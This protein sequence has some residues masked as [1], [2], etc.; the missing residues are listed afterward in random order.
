[1]K[2]C[3]RCKITS[4]TE[5]QRKYCS[6]CGYEKW[7]ASMRFKR[8]ITEGSFVRKQITPLTDD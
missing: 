2:K 5:L 7:L 3:E 4:L 8:R 1:M 6:P